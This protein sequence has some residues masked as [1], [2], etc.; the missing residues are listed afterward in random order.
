MARINGY[1]LCLP[2]N[3]GGN[4]YIVRHRNGKP[5]LAKRPDMTNVVRTKKQL[6]QQSKF[7]LAVKFAQ[8]VVNDPKKRA[9]YKVK[10][11]KSVFQ[12]AIKD[13]LNKK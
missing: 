1:I 6:Q 3:S 10:K 12:T 4:G 7:A 8:S 9:A 2:A 13:Y 11:G 5:Y